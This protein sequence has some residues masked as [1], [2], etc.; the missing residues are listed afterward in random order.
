MRAI[1]LSTVVAFCST[2]EASW[3]NYQTHEINMKVVYYGPPGSATSQN[4]QYIYDRIPKEAKGPLVPLKTGSEPTLFFDYVPPGLGMIRGF[5]LRFHLYSAPGP[6]EDAK[7]RALVLKGADGVVF[8]ADSDPARQTA[9]LAAWK[10][11]LREVEEQGFK[12]GDVLVTVEL[13]HR[14]RPGALSVDAIKR[15]LGLTDQPI[16]EADSATGSGIF[17]SLK[18]VARQILRALAKG[19]RSGEPYAP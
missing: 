6:L 8:V 18:S 13:D 7:S 9:T 2:A 10:E 12:P 19:A 11:L 16:V 1:V 14:N 5:N 15:L 17:E 3:L 4:V